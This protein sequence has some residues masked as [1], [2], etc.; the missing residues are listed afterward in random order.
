MFRFGRTI[1]N[2]TRITTLSMPR[3]VSTVNKKTWKNTLNRD[4]AKMSKRIDKLTY[5]IEDLENTLVQK[6][7]CRHRGRYNQEHV[8][9]DGSWGPGFPAPRS[10]LITHQ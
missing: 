2:K 7:K 8:S 3:F 5:K 10:Y 1:T 6:Q 9:A 4:I